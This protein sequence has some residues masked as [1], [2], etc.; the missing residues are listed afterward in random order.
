MEGLRLEQM[1]EEKVIMLMD[2]SVLP[3]MQQKYIHQRQI[4]ILEK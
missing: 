3:P 2:A 1:K 4:E